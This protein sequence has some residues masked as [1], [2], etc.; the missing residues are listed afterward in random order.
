MKIITLKEEEFENYAKNHPYRNFYQTPNYGRIM[1]HFGFNIHYVGF[2]DNDENLLGASLLIY[3]EAMM[4]HKFVYA[5]KGMLFDYTDKKKT[6]ELADRIKRLLKKQ[7][8]MYLKMDPPITCATYNK[9]E[10]I[11]SYNKDINEI[12]ESLKKAG[13]IHHGKNNFFE[14][15]KPRWEAITS[16]EEDPN[17]LYKKLSKQ[18]RNKIRKANRIG[19]EL[20]ELEQDNL[21]TFFEF[22]KRKHNKSLE[23]YQQFQKEF[24]NEFKVYYA[25]LNTEQFVTYTKDAYEKELD[26][27]E[28]LN[29]IMQTTGQKGTELRKVLNKKM[30]S[31]KLLN[32]HKRNLVWATNLLKQYPEGILVGGIAI[33]EYSDTAYLFIEG[34]DTKYKTLNPTYFLKWEIIKKYKEK[35]FK[36]FNLN[37]VTGKWNEINEYRGLN[38]MKLGYNGQIKEYIGEFD[39]IIKPLTYKLYIKTTK[40]E[41]K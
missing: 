12:M 37:A 11:T 27:N 38:E 16:L 28:D 18:T 33:M 5:P 9:E 1:K 7:N 22:I 39:L 29:K 20:T 34:Y 31:D 32:A 41:K 21:T 10:E 14:T 2:I 24:P 17:I 19:L 40:E 8:F 36:Y 26:I 3:R 13:F 30:E 15:M 25:K 23:Y 6:K 35:G 4:N